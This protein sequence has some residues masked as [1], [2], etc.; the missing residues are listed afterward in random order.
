[1]FEFLLNNE[2][3]PLKRSKT[4]AQQKMVVLNE[5]VAGKCQVVFDVV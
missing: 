4:Y 5:V 2:I 1:M 3:T